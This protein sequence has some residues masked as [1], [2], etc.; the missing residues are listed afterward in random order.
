MAPAA[1]E[2]NVSYRHPALS[3]HPD[4][5]ELKLRIESTRRSQSQPQRC[6]NRF[7]PASVMVANFSHP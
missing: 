7:A 1:L 2:P 6:D 5:T 4:P 3:A